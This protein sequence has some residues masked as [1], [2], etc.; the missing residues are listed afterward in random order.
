MSLPLPLTVR[1]RTSRA[2]RHIT[3]EVGDLQF[4]WSVPGGYASATVDLDR[5][6]HVQ[7]D[8]VG[9]YGNLTVYDARHAGVAWTGRVEDLG[10]SAGADGR[11]WRI[12]AVGPSAHASDR[13]VGLVYADQSLD[14]TAWRR[15]D[16]AAGMAKGDMTIGDNAAV[17]ANPI[18]RLAW[19][20]GQAVATNDR[21]VAQYVRLRDTGQWVARVGA[22]HT[23]G[24]ASTTLKVQAVGR[25]AAGTG[26]ILE[27]DNWTTGSSAIL[28]R[29]GVEHT[30]QYV[31][32]EFRIIDTTTSTSTQNSWSDITNIYIIGSR[33]L[34]T[35]VEK[36]SGYDTTTVLASE[37]VEDLLGRLL[38]LYDGATATVETTSYAI[39]QL[40]YP[41]PATAAKVLGDLLGLHPD[42]YWAAWEKT[43]NGKYRFEFRSWPTTPRYFADV[44][45]GFDSPGSAAEL[46]NAVTVRGRDTAGN[47]RQLVRTSSVPALTAAGITRQTTIDLGDEMWSTANATRAGD[48][49]LAE[50]K[51]PPNAG[52]LTIARPI[53]DTQT[54]RM[55]SP[56][57]IRPGL[58]RVRGVQPTG[59]DALNPA[60]RNGYTVF[61][62]VGCDFHASRGNTI[63][64]LDSRPRTMAQM[65]A[66]AARTSRRRRR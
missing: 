41:D 13:A 29:Y 3:R 20:S 6:L 37:V 14:N 17:N 45:D 7:P 2:D 58:I 55:V 31:A 63:L 23:E 47:I 5:P 44:I 9:Y 60:G 34:K 32:V 40:A 4:R 61:R 52:S 30:T 28:Q 59:E 50:H 49:F 8:E 39:D 10:R 62:V 53:L 54:G 16:M 26:T 1:L 56:W 22:G 46:W 66:D 51:N 19:D 43:V 24:L 12:T 42:M 57:E 36:T 64:E 15:V 18:M 38:V 65:L 35:G 11:V 48:Q 33:Y 21:V 25:S 27:S